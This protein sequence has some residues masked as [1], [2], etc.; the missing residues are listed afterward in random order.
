MHGIEIFNYYE[1]YP[2]VSDWCNKYDLAVMANS[3]IHAS[4]INTYGMQ[5][6]LRPKTLVL[7]REKTLE[8]AREAMFAKRTIGWA[9]N[10][11]WGREPWME[12]LFNAVVE[13]KMI[14]PNHLEF[15]NK[16]SLPI[17][18]SLSNHTFSM[19]ENVTYKAYRPHGVK[20][21]T[22]A[23]WFT[24]MNKA[25]EIPLRDNRTINIYKYEEHYFFM[26]LHLYYYRRLQIA[27]NGEYLVR[28]C[29][30]MDYC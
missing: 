17:T 26:H 10:M 3:D 19:K 8:S 24:A 15:I 2:V 1:Y 12:K 29:R 28:A 7:A 16:S 23:N 13:I 22:V 9:A 20:A 4:E 6:L 30:K 14:S 21:L 25:V 27:K 5:N 11:L 18:V